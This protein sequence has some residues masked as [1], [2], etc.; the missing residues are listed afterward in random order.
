MKM[1]Q[2]QL[3][4][5]R[6]VDVN[7][8]ER[9]EVKGHAQ[10]GIERT[11]GGR[12]AGSDAAGREAQGNALRRN[13]LRNRRLQGKAGRAVYRQPKGHMEEKRATATP[14]KITSR[15]PPGG[16]IVGRLTRLAYQLIFELHELTRRAYQS[17]HYFKTN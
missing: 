17:R 16:L 8:A 1:G 7:A 9:V 5:V 3:Q 4:L 11:A 12:L 10:Q 13:V 15:A 2:L 6:S 14:A